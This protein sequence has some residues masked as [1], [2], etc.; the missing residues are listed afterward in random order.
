MKLNRSEVEKR[1]REIIIDVTGF[2]E[3]EILN[4]NSN[5][6]LSNIG[7]DDISMLDIGFSIEEEYEIEI[8]DMDENGTI[9]LLV[10]CVMDEANGS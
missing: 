1:I 2:S 4:Y 8:F 5:K 6:E 10:N 7:V 3:K 9:D